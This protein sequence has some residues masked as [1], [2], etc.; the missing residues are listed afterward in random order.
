MRHVQPDTPGR[1]ASAP[2]APPSE[3]SDSSPS[4][5]DIPA[6][7]F[8]VVVTDHA[9]PPLVERNMESQQVPLVSPEWLIQSVI[10]G[11]CLGFH[12]LPRYRHDYTS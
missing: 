8:D 11:E 10:S 6:G 9:C 1:R 5:P 4:L 3:A 12:G 7:K 2:G